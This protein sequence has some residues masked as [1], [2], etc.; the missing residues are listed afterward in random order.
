[1]LSSRR[2]SN[3]A[4]AA[5]TMPVVLLMLLFGINLSLASYTAVAAANA[6]MLDGAHPPACRPGGA[7]S[8]R[9][10]VYRGLRHLANL[11]RPGGATECSQ[12]CNPWNAEPTARNS[13]P[14]QGGAG[15][16]SIPAAVRRGEPPNPRSTDS[17][18][19][20]RFRSG[21]WRAT[22]SEPR[23]VRQGGPGR[24]EGSGWARRSG[25]APGQLRGAN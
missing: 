14:C 12:G 2:G 22:I 4:E 7:R 19:E 15:G 11:C 8:S 21:T 16:G 23:P 25:P 24:P 13:P 9:L 5:I 6:D 20:H 17:T 18:D 1:M 3:M 10:A